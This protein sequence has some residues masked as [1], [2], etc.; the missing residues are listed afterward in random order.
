MIIFIPTYKRPETLE[1]A[2]KSIL[3]SDRSNIEERI[4]V[5]VRNNYFSDKKKINNII[6]SLNF[7]NKIYCKAVH[8]LK[9]STNLF[10]W[11]DLIFK[12]G[13][14]NE[15]VMILGDDDLLMPFGIKKRYREI[16]RL[17]GDLLISF[18]NS[19][20]VFFDHG[21]LCWPNLKK[22]KWKKNLNC[23]ENFDLKLD[24]NS[25]FISNHFFRIT[26]DFHK[27]LKLV[28]KW[29]NTQTWS[30]LASGL[31]PYY[32]P[33]AI[34]EV[35]GK[36]LLLSEYSVIRGQVFEESL[37]QIHSNNGS[38]F[39][40]SLLALNIFSNKTLHKNYNFYFR[41]RE[42]FY[43]SLKKNLYE[44]LY[45][46]KKEYTKIKF[47]IKVTKLS[48]I[49]IIFSS[50]LFNLRLL[51]KYIFPFLKSYTYK[52]ILKES[53]ELVDSNKFLDKLKK[54]YKNNQ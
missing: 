17:K 5:L 31:A 30:E 4:L 16:N 38:N 42:Y 51:L 14:K 50:G 25:S 34:K 32:L 53:K 1:L 46:N 20:I 28:K 6:L 11:Y 22:K 18:H 9:E 29:C 35:G 47:G 52:K 19:R 21:N 37:Y 33:Y 8:V 43:N 45:L 44:L 7:D 3:N 10:G 48:L 12:F 23:K 24:M 27:A 39:I 15:V 41:E 26:N 40:Y 54:E 13:K 36:L 49:R 2:L